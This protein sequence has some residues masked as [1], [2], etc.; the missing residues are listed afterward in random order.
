MFYRLFFVGL[1]LLFSAVAPNAFAGSEIAQV[2]TLKGEVHVLRDGGRFP[3]GLGDLLQQADIIE[4]GA[5][6]SVGITFID[7]SQFSAGPNTRIA[8]TQFRFNPTTHEG[9]FTTNIQ[10]GTLT[11]VSGQIAKRRPEAM[12]IVTP[13]TILGFRGTRVAVKVTE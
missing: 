7:S 5:D 1:F 13:T 8:L 6:G 10:R 3:A 2:K 4:T 9:G 11:V 12:K